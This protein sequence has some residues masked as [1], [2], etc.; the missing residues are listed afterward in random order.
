MLVGRITFGKSAT[1][2]GRAH[3]SQQ[4]QGCPTAHE[5]PCPERT[6]GLCFVKVKANVGKYQVRLQ[7]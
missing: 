1:Q 6:E 5:Y 7:G 4:C 2:L 3:S